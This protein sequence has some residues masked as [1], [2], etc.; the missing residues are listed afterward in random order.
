MRQKNSNRHILQKGKKSLFIFGSTGTATEIKELVET[1]YSDMYSKVLLVWYKENW[2][3]DSECAKLLKESE[4]FAIIGFVDYA[5]RKD[6]ASSIME[7]GIEFINVIHPSVVV[8][9]SAKL[10]KGIY[11]AA[12][13][14]IS[15]N[16][17]LQ[18][19][20]IINYNVSIG[21]DA[22]LQS[23]C[24]VLPGA[25]ISGA[26]NLGLGVLIGSNAF[27]FQG[28][29]IGSNTAIDALTYIRKDVEEN[30]LVT[31]RGNRKY[32]KAEC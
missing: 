13:S 8:A 26:V 2:H 22:I 12:N 6:C 31:V 27:V 7:L 25:R 23:H 29:S 11:I 30:M 28:V 16:A 20:I 1:F 3:L 15:S 32:K 17:E 21:H 4:C 24:T 5:M 14:T 9:N 19:N 10:G 18:D